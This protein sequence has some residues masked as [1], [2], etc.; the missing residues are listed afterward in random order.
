MKYPALDPRIIAPT[1]G[2]RDGLDS[3]QASSRRRQAAVMSL[4]IMEQSRF[5]GGS[6]GSVFP[7]TDPYKFKGDSS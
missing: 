3:V 5:S 7:C 2:I 6:K 1:V 4:H